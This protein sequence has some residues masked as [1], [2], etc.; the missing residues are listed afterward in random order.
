[1]N[2]RTYF[3]SILLLLSTV[4]QSQT[5]KREFR[6]IW[7]ASVS[8]IDWPSAPNLSPT[9]QKEEI[10]KILDFYKAQ[11][12]NA[13]ILQVRPTSDA[14]Y[15]SKLEPWS[16]YLTGH[17]GKAP[18]PYYDPLSFWIQEAH[19]RAVEVH[20]WFNPYRITQ[21]LSDTLVSDHIINKNP[22]WG[23]EY[24]NRKYFEP[25]H[26]KVWQFVTEV[27]TDV[28]RRYDID[29]VHFDD[30]FYPYK[31]KDI[32]IP[33]DDAF[34]KYGASF[35]PNN[36]DDWRR[37][38]T[39]TIIQIL[40]SAIKNTKPWVK[41]GISPFGVWRNRSN[42]EIGSETKAG[43]T[44]YDVLYADV[45]KWQRKGW[46][47]YLMPQ[48]YWRD[49]HPAADFST[50]AYWWAD[51][52]YNRG[53]YI[54]LAPYRIDKK[55]DHKLW[56]KDKY[57]IQQ[58]ELLRTLENINGFGF[59]SSKTL[60]K[61][62]LKG[63]NKKLTKDICANKAMVPTMPWI[64]NIAPKCPVNLSRNRNKIIWESGTSENEFDKNRF[65]ALY[66]YEGDETRY[67]KAATKI[68]ALT[69]EPFFI[70]PKG[71]PKGIYR[72]SSLDRLNNES[73]LSKPF[74]IK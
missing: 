39:D 69:G 10:I 1:M 11:N 32:A 48:L 18:S 38:N 34:K 22:S 62:E 50:L 2:I 30:Y 23:W 27:V 37:H 59:F 40:S 15:A 43:T 7:I 20:A 61:P 13:I 47:D 8:N 16:R 72:V 46:I 71:I 17:Q 5:N 25:G 67:L 60:F 51:Y 19:K 57:F 36:K 28:V 9:K 54:G 35:Y 58:I 65:F 6:A 42:D 70:F 52:S 14:I 66:K 64:D 33:D 55:S 31:I 44:N 21:S 12:I 3:I 74:E 24:G 41:F 68:I 29:A 26:P 4:L 73:P 45:I 53:L 63:L 49:D 56:K